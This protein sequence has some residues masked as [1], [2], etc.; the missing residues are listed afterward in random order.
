MKTVLLKDAISKSTIL[1]K[2]YIKYPWLS[3]EIYGCPAF[4]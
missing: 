1:K 2:L 3:I 4:D